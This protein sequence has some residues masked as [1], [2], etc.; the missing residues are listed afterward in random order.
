MAMQ[1]KVSAR[2]DDNH[3]LDGQGAGRAGLEHAVVGGVCGRHGEHVDQ[4]GD[5]GVLPEDTQKAARQAG[6][7]RQAVT[8]KEPAH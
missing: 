1:P 4:A 2:A 5:P 3:G 7:G 6:M 8:R